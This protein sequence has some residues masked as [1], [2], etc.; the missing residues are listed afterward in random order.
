MSRAATQNSRQHKQTQR[1]PGKIAERLSMAKAL[2]CADPSLG[3]QVDA[4]KTASLPILLPHE[5]VYKLVADGET[6]LWEQ[7]AMGQQALRQLLQ[8]QDD[9][10]CTAIALSVWMDGTPCN[11]DRSQSL[12]TICFGFPGLGGANSSL[13]IP[14]TVINK[15]L[16]QVANHGFNLGCCGLVH[17]MHGCRVLA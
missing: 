11:W 9:H 12:E 4:K 2:H 3:L 6:R 1:Y 10:Q 17:A 13:R 15:T 8:M 16:C 14:I 5:V 7:G